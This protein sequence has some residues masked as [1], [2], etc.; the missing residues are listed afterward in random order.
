MYNVCICNLS[1]INASVVCLL[2]WL[3]CLEAE[4]T[5]TGTGTGITNTLT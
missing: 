2:S 3:G 5:G 4:L 1:D